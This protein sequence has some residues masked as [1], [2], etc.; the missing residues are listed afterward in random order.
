LHVIS[1]VPSPTTPGLSEITYGRDSLD[2]T[3]KAVG[4]KE[5]DNPKTVYDP[6][7]ISTDKMYNAGKE[8]AAKGYGS[9]IASGNRVY[10]A[11]HDGITFRI[12][13]D[14]T[15]TTVTNFHPTMK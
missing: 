9:A 7:I 2:R 12:Y 15:P 11:S 13:L 10:S 1:E 4:I 8:A 6:S 5:F 14:K 3:G